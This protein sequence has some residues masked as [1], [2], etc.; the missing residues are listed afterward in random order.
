MPGDLCEAQGGA[1]LIGWIKKHLQT[2]LGY[3]ACERY[4]RK[5]EYRHKVP[6]SDR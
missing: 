5:Q 4:R 1:E 2:L 3:S 6:G